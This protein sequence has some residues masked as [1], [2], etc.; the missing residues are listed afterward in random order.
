MSIN[1][2]NESLEGPVVPKQTTSELTSYAESAPSIT[3]VDTTSDDKLDVISNPYEKQDMKKVLERSYMVDSVDWI[4]SAGQYQRLKTVHFPDK[5]LAIENIAD[6]LAQFAF[7]KADVEVEVK[8]NATPFH[9]GAL[10][11]SYVSHGNEDTS[12]C[13]DPIAMLNMNSTVMSISS[14]NSVK[15]RIPRTGPTLFDKLHQETPNEPL[16]SIGTLFIDVLDPMS[17]LSGEPASN[18][19]IT[20]FASFV[21]PRVAG[22][23]V[24]DLLPAMVKQ[25]IKRLG[26]QAKRVPKEKG[27]IEKKSREEGIAKSKGGLISGIAEAAGS[28][29]PIIAATPFAEFAPLAA[30]AGTFA[31]FLASLGLCK[32]TDVSSTTQTVLKPWSDLTHAHGLSMA[33]KMAMHP[34]AML[35]DTDLSDLKRHTIKEVIQ[36]PCHVLGTAINASTAT[37]ATFLHFP[38]HP[39]LSQ[40]AGGDTFYPSWLAYVSQLFGKWRGGIKI[41]LRFVTSQYTTARVRIVHFPD[42]NLPSDLEAFSGDAPNTVV[43]IRG[44]TDYCFT[45]PYL[46]RFPYLPVGGFM[47]PAD[48]AN[49]ATAMPWPTTWLSCHLVNPVNI[50][51]PTGNSLIYVHMYVAAAEDFRFGEYCGLQIRPNQEPLLRKRTVKK[52]K[53]EAEVKKKSM[54]TFFAKPFKPLVP[55]MGGREVGLV[56]PEH[57]T[58]FVEI[59]K[60][61]TEGYIWNGISMSLPVTAGGFTPLTT[62]WWIF[63]MFNF[64]RGSFR[65]KLLANTTGLKKA[66]KQIFP[67]GGVGTGYTSDI[68]M[69]SPDTPL[70]FEVPWAEL[71]FC[72]PYWGAS[73]CPQDQ[74]VGSS[75]AVECSPINPSKTYCSIGEDFMF[76]GLLTPPS[77]TF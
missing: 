50:P 36:K 20:I 21:N 54:E 8:V 12:E 51:D 3:V 33:P 69:H 2:N 39:G 5:L 72:T 1:M 6:K 55:A 68:V 18:L 70:E 28:F 37:N 57:V 62:L 31:P 19:R 42:S 17:T 30:I 22:Y 34:D 56:L 7:L 15:I 13:N 43:D 58:S 48:S 25:K 40:V 29:A 10:N 49:F 11:I 75:Y 46:S 16:G 77:L 24:S 60:R 52:I 73:V 65:F 45:V 35:A 76:G 67:S 71:S 66:E 4:Y 38:V 32:P 41:M 23:G 44:N 47:G 14:T 26:D 61:P 74:E 59:L 53:E 27:V 64:Y 9:I 63:R